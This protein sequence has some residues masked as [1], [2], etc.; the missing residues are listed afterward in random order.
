MFI[1]V[2]TVAGFVVF[3]TY[4]S[5]NRGCISISEEKIALQKPRKVAKSHSAISIG[6]HHNGYK[7]SIDEILKLKLFASAKRTLSNYRH[8]AS[9]S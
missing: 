4:K 3:I 8:I 7:Q 6:F 2:A 5:K 1:L 9:I